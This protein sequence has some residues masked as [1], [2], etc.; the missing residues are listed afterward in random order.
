MNFSQRIRWWSGIVF[1]VLAITTTINV[2]ILGEPL[3]YFDATLLVVMEIRLGLEY[4]EGAKS[5]DLEE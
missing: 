2:A 5:K 3:D 1:F 4:F